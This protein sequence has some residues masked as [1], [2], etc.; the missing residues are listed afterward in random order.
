MPLYPLRERSKV[1]SFEPIPLQSRKRRAIIEIMK[2]TNELESFGRL[3]SCLSSSD[4]ILYK[5]NHLSE[6]L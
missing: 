5:E 4:I 1:S 2:H 3:K 6:D